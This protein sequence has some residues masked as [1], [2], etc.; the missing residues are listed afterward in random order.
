MR[1]LVTVLI[2][3]L[4]PISARATTLP[5]CDP[6]DAQCLIDL[7]LRQTLR[8]ELAEKKLE[9]C[10]EDLQKAESTPRPAPVCRSCWFAG[11][12]GTA[13]LLVILGMI[14]AN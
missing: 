4:A 7:S 1:W 10:R 14:L 5:P 2:I 6:N 3:S 13:A 9:G 12:V 11:G 8:A